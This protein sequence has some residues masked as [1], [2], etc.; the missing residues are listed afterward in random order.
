MTDDEVIQVFEDVDVDNSGFIDYTEWIAGTISKKKIL[1]ERNLT[2]A[3]EAFDESGDGKISV[4]ELKS[5]LGKGQTVNDKAWKQIMK[6]VDE[7]KDGFIDFE[8]FKENMSRL[9]NYV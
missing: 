8:E 2:L 5:I 1:S 7:N 3:F 6:E 9:L 4:D